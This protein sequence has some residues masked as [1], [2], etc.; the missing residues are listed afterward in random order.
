[1]KKERTIICTNCKELI[2]HHGKGLCKQC[3]SKEYMKE[4]NQKPEV[5]EHMKE[6]YHSP[7][8]KKS[9]R[10]GMLKRLERMDG[11]I[12]DFTFYEWQEKVLETK[13]ICPEC[14]ENVG[15]NKLTLDHIVPV[16]KAPEGF[17]Y[18]IKD[19]TPLC[20]SCNSSKSNSGDHNLN[21]TMENFVEGKYLGEVL[22]MMEEK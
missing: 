16:S 3:Y 10:K 2:K 20:K 21:T 5:I 9:R 15:I 14:K 7:N 13:G 18:T 22:A 8:G 6:Y 11:V 19:V 12:H 17:T 4:Y 1:M